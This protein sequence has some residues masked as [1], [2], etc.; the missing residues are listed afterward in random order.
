MSRIQRVIASSHERLKTMLRARPGCFLLAATLALPAVVQAEEEPLLDRFRIEIGEFFISHASTSAELAARVGPITAGTRIDFDQ[1]LEVSDSETVGRIDGFYRFTPRS[2]IDFS[3]FKVDRD[4]T[5]LTPF[6]IDFG[7]ISIPA[8]TAV[9][10]FFDQEVLRAAYGFSFYNVPKVELGLS[11][12]LHIS[13]IGMGIQAPAKADQA[14][15]TAP[16]PVVGVFFRYN[17]SPRWRLV[18]KN[19]IFF[20]QTDDFEGSLTDIR[21][22]VEHQTFK[23]AGFGLGFNRIALSIEA[24]DGEFRGEFDNTL[25]GFQLYVFAN[26][27]K[28]AH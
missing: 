5:A 15:T 1:D 11:A 7:D 24:D 2:R 19:E 21:F 8:G 27:G 14:E 23:N 17:L 6:D 18:S 25:S 9:R 16:L 10:S 20:I 22:G 26:F 4:G 3:Y 13:K 28:L 12:G